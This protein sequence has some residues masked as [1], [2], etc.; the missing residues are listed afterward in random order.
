MAAPLHA[1]RGMVSVT[2]LVGRV[3]LRAR[4]GEVPKARWRVRRCMLEAVP[5]AARRSAPRSPGR[6]GSCRGVARARA[7]CGL[8]E[9]AALVAV[10][11][12]ER[13]PGLLAPDN[14]SARWSSRRRHGGCCRNC[15]H[16]LGPHSSL[17]RALR[18][19]GSSIL[20]H[21]YGQRGAGARPNCGPRRGTQARIW[22]SLHERLLATTPPGW[23]QHP[24]SRHIFEAGAEVCPPP[25][26]SCRGGDHDITAWFLGCGLHNAP[27]DHCLL[28]LV[29]SSLPLCP[30]FCGRPSAGLCRGST[31]AFVGASILSSWPHPRRRIPHSGR[32][33]RR[34]RVLQ[35]NDDPFILPSLHSSGSTSIG[36]CRRPLGGPTSRIV[37]SLFDRRIH[38]TRPGAAAQPASLGVFVRS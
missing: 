17:G 26:R 35:H 34:H 5:R 2:C 29:R 3:T 16:P 31:G 14:V 19:S 7:A 4:E 9:R 30:T 20:S 15:R 23:L 8:E 25:G 38:L 18:G 36:V 28:V 21:H 13:E 6:N 32:P 1:M 22:P 24:K 33:R 37:H 12:R 11:G 10:E 27:C